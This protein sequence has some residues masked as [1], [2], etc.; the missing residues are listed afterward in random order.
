LASIEE[1]GQ[2]F[3]LKRSMIMKLIYLQARANRLEPLFCLT[4]FWLAL[5][6]YIALALFKYYGFLPWCLNDES[7]FSDVAFYGV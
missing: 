5:A 6:I 2:T 4:Y 7:Q 1:R 3:G